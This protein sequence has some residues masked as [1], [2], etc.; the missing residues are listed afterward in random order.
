MMYANKITAKNT[1]IIGDG[2]IESGK[3]QIRNMSSGEQ[4]EVDISNLNA[5][6]EII[7]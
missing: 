2:E 6:L 5:I 4:T 7:K 1:L 3:A